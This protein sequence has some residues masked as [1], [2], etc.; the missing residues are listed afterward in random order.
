MRI[1]KI[2]FVI[3][4]LTAAGTPSSGPP[5]ENEPSEN[6]EEMDNP[7]NA[8]TPQQAWALGCA[9]ILNERNHARHDLLGTQFRTKKN[10]DGCRKFLVTSGWDIKNR[11]ELLDSLIWLESGGHR[12]KF[13]RLGRKLQALSYAEYQNLLKEYQSDK[14][15][16]F[17]TKIARELYAALGEK[18]LYGW[19]LSRYICLC[20]WG[21]LA[22]YLTEDEAWEKIMPVARILQSKFDSWQDLGQNYLIG[23]YF[24]SYKNT[25]E[26]GFLYEDAYLR[27]LDMPSSPWNMLPWDLDLMDKKLASVPGRTTPVA[28]NN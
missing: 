18:S 22:G 7:Q 12:Q 16:L 11:T 5:M 24:W 3:I 25:K 9:A 14:E 17:E 20:R 26:N 1:L 10:V 2:S 28:K 19:D 21:Y 15:L 27:L 23:R 13:E 8:I 4:I 6:T